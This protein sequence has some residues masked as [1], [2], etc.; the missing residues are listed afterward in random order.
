MRSENAPSATTRAL[1]RALL[2]ASS[3]VASETFRAT[4]RKRTMPNCAGE[5]SLGSHRYRTSS[6]S[7]R[8]RSIASSIALAISGTEVVHR[9]PHLEGA[10]ITRELLA[11]VS[12]I[13][14]F[15]AGLNVR[16]VLGH[17]A[18]CGC[19]CRRIRQQTPALERN[20]QPFVRIERE[21]VGALESAE[22][23]LSFKR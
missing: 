5:R 19:Q 21:A 4:A 23:A 16:E 11:T 20:E 2:S 10:R 7:R 14:F 6:S 22:Q 3:S 1:I 13:H 15:L 8:A 12:E 9:Q 17:D 18:K